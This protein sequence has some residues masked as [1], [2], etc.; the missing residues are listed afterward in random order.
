MKSLNRGLAFAL[1]AV[2]LAASGMPVYAADTV[3]RLDFIKTVFGRIVSEQYVDTTIEFADVS[4]E[5]APIVAAAVA[6]GIANGHDD[7]LFRPDDVTTVEQAVAMVI[8]FLDLRDHALT[9]PDNIPEDRYVAP[10]I[11]P[12]L[13]W[14]MV[15][16][17]EL[18]EH[19]EIGA[20]ATPE[21]I[22][23]LKQII[24]KHREPL[25]F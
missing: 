6:A 1:A 2:I 9:L 4:E 13:Q 14:A 24:V 23:I 15:Y 20:P 25:W 21:L 7:G 17:D 19:F 5:D 18:L 11:R 16:S 12:Y 8:K 10:W 3:T 22:D